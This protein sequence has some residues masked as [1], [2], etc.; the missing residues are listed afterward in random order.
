MGK[1][2]T[3][4]EKISKHK[5]F[6]KTDFGKIRCVLTG[7]EIPFREEEFNEYQQVKYNYYFFWQY[8][9]FLIN[10]LIRFSTNFSLKKHP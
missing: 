10:I 7:H 2:L 4:D 1:D 8:L 5:H 3:L 9:K 6:E